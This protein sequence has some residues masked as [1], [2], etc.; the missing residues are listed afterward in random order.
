MTTTT[1]QKKKIRKKDISE[2]FIFIYSHSYLRQERKMR[3]QNQ[4]Q[5]LHLI[6]NNALLFN[7]TFP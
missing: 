7:S 5:W 2:L 3:R 6:R 1:K 4:C